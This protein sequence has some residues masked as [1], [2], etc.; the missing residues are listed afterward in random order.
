[1]GQF[2]HPNVV[3]LYGIISRIDPVMIVMEYLEKGSLDRHLQVKY[4]TPEIS[5]N[6]VCHF[7]FCDELFSQRNLDKLGVPTL[8][9]LAHGVASGM[10]YLSKIGFVHRVRTQRSM[11]PFYLLT[12]SFIR[13]LLHVT[14]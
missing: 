3:K 7:L 6:Y 10:Y 1:M 9:K 11:L 5:T 4:I 2:N 8:L 13:I 14:F 12:L